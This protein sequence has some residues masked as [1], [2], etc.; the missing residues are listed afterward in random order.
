MKTPLIAIVDD[1]LCF[2]NYLTTFLESRGY[3][4]RIYGR[5]EDLT[6]AVDRGDI[7]DVV[8]LDVLMPGLDG[9]ATL[10]K[11]KATCTELQ[12]IMLSGREH[13]TT[14][15]EAPTLSAVNYVL[16]PA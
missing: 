5:G 15:L 16:K 14:I 9:L 11:L 13:A 8:L 4:T 1:D 6:V 2:A 12:V 10:K 3:Q 7:P